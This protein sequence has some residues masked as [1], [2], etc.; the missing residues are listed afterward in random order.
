MWQ[1]NKERCVGC[2]ICERVCP[3]EAVALEAGVAKLVRPE[4]CTLCGVCADQCPQDA[5]RVER[6]QLEERALPSAG[7]PQLVEATAV[8][9]SLLG[10]SRHPVGIRLLGRDDP[11]PCELPEPPSPLRH[12]QAIH[13]ASEGEVLLIPMEKQAC[14]AARA[15]LGMAPLPEK[16]ASGEVPH[17]HG[18]ARSR[19]VAARIMAEIPKL[20]PG[21]IKATVVGALD[22]MPCEPQ[23]IVMIVNPLQAMWIANAFLYDQGGPRLTANF[24]GMQASCGDA[25]VIPY[26][27]GQVNFSV[28]CY[29]CRSAGGLAPEEMYV[30][31]PAYELPRLVA[32]LLG[33]RRAIIKFSFSKRG[34]VE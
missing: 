31:L 7:L 34:G 11:V 23:V 5:I 8:L 26:K 29:G 4:L 25:T 24:A 1:L 13:E 30:G 9:R 21:S 10:L 14:F 6:P 33:L 18:L 27:T 28:G 15:A 32:N 12:C 2:G 17:L 3:V 19:E 22:H 20:P 16:V